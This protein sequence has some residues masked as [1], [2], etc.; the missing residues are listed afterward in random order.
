MLD[1]LN[2]W[3]RN[4][5][6]RSLLTQTV[7]RNGKVLVKILVGIGEAEPTLDEIEARYRRGDFN[8]DVPRLFTNV[9]HGMVP[10]KEVWYSM[11]ESSE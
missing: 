11:N 3:E 5:S 7:R 4:E 9:R 2:E 6:I 1:V 8:E 10:V